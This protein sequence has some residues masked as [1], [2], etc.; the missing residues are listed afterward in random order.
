MA[1][2]FISYASEDRERAA[3]LASRLEQAGFTVWWDRHICGGSNFALEIEREIHA[4][5]SVVVAWSAAAYGS[6]WVRDEASYAR[7]E[8]KLVPLRLDQTMPPMGF[9]QWQTLD[10][11]AWQGEADASCFVALLESVRRVLDP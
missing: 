9:R 4:A 3:Q 7:D 5:R 2:V 10:F 8:R 11:S 1:D 6:E